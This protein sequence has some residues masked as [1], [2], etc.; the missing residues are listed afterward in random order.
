MQTL[1]LALG[2][3]LVA[4]LS[5]LAPGRA[6]PKEADV[7]G[8]WYLKAMVTDRVSDKEPEGVTPLSIKALQGGNFELKITMLED[9]QCQEMKVLLEKTD[10]PGKYSAYGGKRTVYLQKA[11]TRGHYILSCEGELNGEQVRMGKLLGRDPKYSQKALGEFK[12]VVAQIGLDPKRIFLM[13]QM[14][15]CTPRGN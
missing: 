14:E 15:T 2:F 8:Q 13:E 4:A 10:E 11:Q 5:A 3:G 1:L 12:K 7:S 6:F 9:G